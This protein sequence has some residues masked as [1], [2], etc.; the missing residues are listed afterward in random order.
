MNVP[1]ARATVKLFIEGVPTSVATYNFVK[2][3]SIEE[4]EEGSLTFETSDNKTINT[5]LRYLAEY[6][7]DN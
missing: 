2:E 1:E 6:P 7:T 4:D 3:D 5:N